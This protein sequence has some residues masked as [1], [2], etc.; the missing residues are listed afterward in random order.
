M[1]Q[2]SQNAVVDKRAVGF[3]IL[4][5]GSVSSEYRLG[6]ELMQMIPQIKARPVRRLLGGCL[7]K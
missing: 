6:A 3:E 2:Y 7:P 5:S 4:E 1:M